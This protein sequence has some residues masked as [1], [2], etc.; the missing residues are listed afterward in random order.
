[1]RKGLKST[2]AMG[3]LAAGFVTANATDIIEWP[4][5]LAVVSRT[6]PPVSARLFLPLF[7]R[8]S[9]DRAGRH[10]GFDTYEYPGDETM[11]AWKTD[12]PYEWVGYYLPAPCH[13]GT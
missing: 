4:A 10:L 5:A 1:M 9:I 2:F 12:A 13:D 7:P 3:A 11:R 8:D 6:I